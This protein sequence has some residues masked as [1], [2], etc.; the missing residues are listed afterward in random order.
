MNVYYM[1]TCLS[2]TLSATTILDTVTKT[3]THTHTHT[4]IY[5]YIYM[6]VYTDT[7]SC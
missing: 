1:T 3:H 4:H 7:V 2:F 5:I 6:Y